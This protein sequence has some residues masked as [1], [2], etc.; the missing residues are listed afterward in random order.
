MDKI[1]DMSGS[2]P[3][4]SMKKYYPQ[5]K[6]SKGREIKTMD[7]KEV[8]KMIYN[9][10]QKLEKVKEWRIKY[11]YSCSDCFRMEEL[12]ELKETLEKHV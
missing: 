6:Q 12:I 11:D 3:A 4:P 8:V 1:D 5:I 9:L 7:Y 10:K 2:T